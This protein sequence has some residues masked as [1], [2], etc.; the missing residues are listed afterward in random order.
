MTLEDLDLKLKEAMVAK[1]EFETSILRGL[2]SAV[3]NKEIE[4]RGKSQDLGEADV[5]DVLKKEAK[6]RKEASE[7]FLKAQRKDLAEKEEK[8][9]EYIL[10]FLP[11]QLSLEEAEK[12]VDEVL[13]NYPD[14]T[15]KDFGKI[16]K[17]VMEKSSGGCDGAMVSSIVKNKL[18]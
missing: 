17:E 13:K 3:R 8:E 6:K 15:V 5:L 7:L 14:A 9:L 11:K 12:I 2:I 4:K 1:N 10:Q 18:K 16:L